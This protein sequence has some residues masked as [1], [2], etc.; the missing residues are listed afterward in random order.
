MNRHAKTLLW[1]VALALLV[2]A[3]GGWWWWR[4]G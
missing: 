2:S 3:V 1:I 4:G